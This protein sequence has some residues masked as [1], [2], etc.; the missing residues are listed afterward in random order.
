MLQD[1]WMNGGTTDDWSDSCNGAG[2][3]FCGGSYGPDEL[4]ERNARNRKNFDSMIAPLIAAQR[5]AYTP[6][7]AQR[8]TRMKYF[9]KRSFYG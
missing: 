1:E 2:I 9:G 8:Q 6:K 5:P 7:R 4:A 3:F